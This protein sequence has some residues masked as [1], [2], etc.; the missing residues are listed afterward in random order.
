[1]QKRGVVE[2][3]QA[4]RE[5]WKTGLSPWW[6]VTVNDLF[7]ANC[8]VVHIQHGSSESWNPSIPLFSLIPVLKVISVTKETMVLFWVYM[9][10]H[11]ELFFNYS[12]SHRF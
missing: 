6:D 4:G 12:R 7:L 11:I 9:M 5:G 8:A 2:E 10:N 3:R 1:M